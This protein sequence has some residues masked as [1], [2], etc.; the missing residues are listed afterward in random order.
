MAEVE[1]EKVIP[2][3][4]HEPS[5]IGEGFIWGAVAVSLGLLAASAVL[6]LWLYPR[7]ALDR[8]LSLPLPV[9]PAPRLQASPRTDMQSFYAQELQRLQGTGWVD[10]AHG[11]VHIPI[12][13]AMR[14]VAQE[15]IS[16]W[17]AAPAQPP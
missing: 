17:P 2:N 14:Q 1:A 4:R 12:A 8:T 5:D 7:S 11:V 15:G 3:A 9:F 6:V 16:G 13:D 10:K